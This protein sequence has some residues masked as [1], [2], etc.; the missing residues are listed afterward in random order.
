VRADWRGCAAWEAEPAC[1]DCAAC[2]GPAYDAV[3]IGPRDPVRKAAP[4]L[5]V[6]RDGRIQI[7]R[8]AD[9]HCAALGPGNRCRIYDDRPRCCRGFEKLGANCLDARRRV[10]LSPRWPG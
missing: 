6:V 4:T 1:L 7:A 10:G 3:E 9:N 8:T 5:V 2:C